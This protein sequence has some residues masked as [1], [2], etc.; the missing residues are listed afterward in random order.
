M[1]DY[2]L[3]SILD[4]E[5]TYLSY[6]TPH[7]RNVDSDAVDDVHT[8]KFLNTIS[9][10]DLPNHNLRLKVG[11]PVMLLRNLDKKLRLCNGTRLITRMRKYVFEGKNISG[12]NI[13]DKVFIPKLSLIPSDV[14]IRLKFQRRQF[15]LMVSFAMT[16]NKSQGKSLKYVRVYLL[17]PVFSHV[18]L[19]VAFSK[20]T[21]R[22]ELKIWVN[23]AFGPFKILQFGFW[24]L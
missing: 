9:A 7:A 23:G 18:Q 1:N 10:S 3:D 14:R 24:S 21:S 17:S 20:V 19:Y 2:V 6:D 11:V 22:E 16:I 12:S 15:P 13:G 8:L 4:E 5:K